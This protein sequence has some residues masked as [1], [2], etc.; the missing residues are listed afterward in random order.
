[1]PGAAATRKR[2]LKHYKLDKKADA[3]HYGIGLKELWTIDQAKH[4]PGLVIHGAGWPLNS[5]NPGGS[6][7]T[8]WKTTRSTSASSS[9]CPTA[10]PTFPLRRDAS[11]SKHHPVLKQYLEGGKRVSYGARAITKALQLLLPKMV[12]PAAA[13]IG[14]DPAP[15]TSPRSRA[16]QPP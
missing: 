12:F 1:L 2:L 7:S 13:L 15:S 5:A 3:Q 11:A 4:E 6:S 9:T 10:T 8:T 16:A 14:C